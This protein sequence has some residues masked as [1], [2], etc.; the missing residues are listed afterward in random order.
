MLKKTE[1]LI[2]KNWERKG[3]PKA[4]R[5]HCRYRCLMTWCY[6]ACSITNIHRK[7]KIQLAKMHNSP[8]NTICSA[9]N[10]DFYFWWIPHWLDRIS[11]FSKSNSYHSRTSLHHCICSFR[12][13]KT[14]S[15]ITISTFHS[16]LHY[17]N[18]KCL[19][20]VIVKAINPRTPLP[21]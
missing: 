7:W 20:H 21:F 5:W 1:R 13:F 12:D 15:I 4:L 18:Q 6:E 8:L 19:S 2:Q 11:Y 16:K 14:S 17:G 3:M 9:D 10:H